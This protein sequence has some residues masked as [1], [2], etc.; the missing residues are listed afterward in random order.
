MD[1][2][3]TRTC[4]RLPRASRDMLTVA[5]ASPVVALDQDP[6]EC[7]RSSV[8]TIEILVYREDGASAP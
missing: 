5:V 4:A 6:Y 3:G 8:T 1:L 7:S 2:L